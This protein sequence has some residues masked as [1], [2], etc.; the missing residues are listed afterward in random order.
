MRQRFVRRLVKPAADRVGRGVQQDSSS[1]VRPAGVGDRDE[2]RRGEA[3]AGGDLD[4]QNRGVAAE[5]HR[6]DA[7][8]VGDAGAFDFQFGENLRR[9]SCRRRRAGVALWRLPTH[10]PGHRRCRRRCNRARSPCPAP[11]RSRGEWRVCSLRHRARPFLPISGRSIGSEY[12]APTFSQPPPL[13]IKPHIDMRFTPRLKVEDRRAGAQVVA[14]ILAGDRID[15]IL[16]QVTDG[17]RFGD[18]GA[19]RLPRR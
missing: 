5:A 9:G 6:T 4:A 1:A 19:G 15:R 14:G 12:C 7:Q 2:E 8:A 18:G 3:I 17:G 11:S 10:S 13:S 16:A